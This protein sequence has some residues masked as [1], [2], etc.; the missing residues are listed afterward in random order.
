MEFLNS[1]GI[2]TRLL[3]AGNLTKQP[4]Y[5]DVVYRVSGDL[6]NTDLIMNSTFWVG[7]Y[8]GLSEVMLRYMA[9]QVHEFVK[10]KVND[11]AVVK[12]S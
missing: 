2:G 5:R 1:R 11:D 8:P 6:K 10:S 4:A 7:T 9:S 12:H 3:F